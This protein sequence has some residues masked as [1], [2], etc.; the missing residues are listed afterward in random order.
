VLKTRSA[1]LT[2]AGVAL[3]ALILLPRPFVGT[4]A[5]ADQAMTKSQ[6]ETIVHDYLLA[7]PEML[8]EMASALQMKQQHAAD[9][10]RSTAFAKEHAALYNS[11]LQVV[12]GNPKGD[13]TLVE[14][15]DYNCTYCRHALDDT[16]A[17]LKSD[18]NLRFVLKE[19]PVLSAASKEAAEVAV[20]VNRI[21]PQKYLAFHRALLGSNQEA[22][23]AVAMAAAEKLGISKSALAKELA[24]PSI[25]KPIAQ[26][27]D[28][29]RK[30]SIDGT[31]TY[32]IGHTVMSGAV[33][34]AALK[35]AVANM[36]ACGKA[37]CS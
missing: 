18:P 2:I 4:A 22:T 24:S 10:Q 16:N 23:G 34:L 35:S 28:L 3:A 31:P 5:A 17:L 6:V 36:R 33:G 19:F 15:F 21:A 30:L 37:I 26:A 27:L 32:V 7:H 13:V 29:A 14:F 12:L 20:A 9:L 11:P 1:L 25:D 8:Q